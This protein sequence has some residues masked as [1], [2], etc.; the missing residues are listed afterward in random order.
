MVTSSAVYNVAY[1][2]GVTIDS[3]TPNYGT[4]KFTFTIQLN[5][6]AHEQGQSVQD[7]KL[8]QELEP[9]QKLN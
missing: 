6:S 2:D 7:V 5:L 1:E 4:I 9:I 3:V 8:A